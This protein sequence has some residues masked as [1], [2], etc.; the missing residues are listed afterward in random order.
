VQSESVLA[1]HHRGQQMVAS[2]VSPPRSRRGGRHL[3]PVVVGLLALTSLH[4]WADAPPEESADEIGQ[5]LAN[6][7]SNIWALF[8]EVDYDWNNG[9]LS[10]G[11]MRTGQAVIMQPVMPIPLTADAMLMTRPTLPVILSV[12]RP[13]GIKDPLTGEATFDSHDGLGDL[14]LPLLYSRQPQPGSRWS[15]AF[16]PTLQFPTHSGDL[17]TDTWEAGPAAAIIYKTEHVTAGTLT[18]YWWDYSKDGSDV[19]DTSHGSVLYFAMWNLPDAWQVGFNP[20]ITYDHQ[21]DKDNKWNVPVGVVV[22]KTVKFGKL[23]VKFQFGVEKSVVR[24]DALGQD[25]QV[26][27]NIIPVIPGL[28]EHPLF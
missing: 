19:Q 14:Q 3:A 24:Q 16:G 6:P 10:H 5:K 25:F 28:I 2:G 27:L 26:K 11:T 13:D 8:T 22:A 20:T 21:Q 7:L 9:D 4:V 12:D 18:Q 15:Y 23:P 1:V 17:G